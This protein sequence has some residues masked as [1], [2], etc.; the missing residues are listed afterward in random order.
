LS[1]NVLD[2]PYSTWIPYNNEEFL[3]VFFKY[4]L[5]IYVDRFPEFQNIGKHT[6]YG[7]KIQKTKPSEGYHIWHSENNN[8]HNCNRVLLLL[9]I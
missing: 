8:I 3:E 7:L 5:P 6:V 2:L 1:V 9:Y 4:I